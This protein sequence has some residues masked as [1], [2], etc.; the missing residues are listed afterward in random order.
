M[1]NVEAGSLISG[2]DSSGDADTVATAK[3]V[4]SLGGRKGSTCSADGVVVSLAGFIGPSCSS[5]A[6]SV[7]RST[8]SKKLIAASRLVRQ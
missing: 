2:L 1:G 3:V 4:V 7:E 8:F 6:R 5:S